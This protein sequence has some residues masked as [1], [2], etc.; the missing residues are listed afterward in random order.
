MVLGGGMSPADATR[1]RAEMNADTQSC[2][3]YMASKFTVEED[4][5]RWSCAEEGS[6]A[7]PSTPPLAQL[8]RE[9]LRTAGSQRGRHHR[10]RPVTDD[11]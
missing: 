10:R 2:D 7:G 11:L 4:P 9:F 1:L 8:M 3:A 5:A 6:I